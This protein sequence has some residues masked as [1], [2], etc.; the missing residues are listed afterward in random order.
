[1]TQICFSV[2]WLQSASLDCSSD[3]SSSIHAHHYMVEIWTDDERSQLQSIHLKCFVHDQR[4]C[5]IIYL[6]G[7]VDNQGKCTITY[8]K[9]F[10]ENHYISQSCFITIL[11]LGRQTWNHYSGCCFLFS[12][13]LLSHKI[14]TDLLVGWSACMSDHMCLFACLSVSY[15]CSLIQVVS[16]ACWV[17]WVMS[18]DC[19]LVW[20]CHMPVLSYKWCH[21]SVTMLAC[22]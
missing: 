17:T 22:P 9:G 7:F 19:S 18:H 6:K 4:M 5:T 10:V 2:H 11:Q 21:M 16:R 12:F 1:M 13:F 3:F 14:W 15:A 8:L 20:V